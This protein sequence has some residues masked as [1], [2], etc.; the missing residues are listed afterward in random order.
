MTK[1]TKYLSQDSRSPDRDFN[2]GPP[3]YEMLTT[4]PLGIVTKGD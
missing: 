4:Q 3:E 1:F 2:L